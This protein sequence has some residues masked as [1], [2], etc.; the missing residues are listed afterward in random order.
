MDFFFNPR[1]VTVVGASDKGPGSFLLGNL[2]RG[3]Q[4]KVFPVN[5]N[6]QE[7]GGLPCYPSVD[8]IPE[9]VDLALLL[10]P[11]TLAPETLTACVK[12][13]VKGAIIQS[14]GFAEVGEKGRELS[15]QALEIARQGGLRL[16]GPNCMGLV[17]VPNKRFFTLMQPAI[18]N[19]VN[20]PGSISLVVQSGM[21]SAGFLADLMSRHSIGVAKVCSLGNKLDVDECDVLEFLMADPETKVVAMYL[22]S[23]KR[24]RRFIELASVSPKPVVVLKSGVSQAGAKAALSHTASLAGNARLTSNMLAAAGVVQ[25]N[26]FH[27]MMDMALTLNSYPSLPEGGRA[28]VITFSGG[29]GILTCDLLE[30]YGL[31]LAELSPATKQG[32]AEIFPPWMPPENPV[33]LFPAMARMGRVVALEKACEI[34]MADPEV[35]L[36]VF[37]H[38]IGVEPK[39][40][41]IATLKQRSLETGKPV[42]FWGLGLEQ[43]VAAF[44]RQAH[45][46]GV[47]VYGELSRLVECLAQASRWQPEQMGEPISGWTPEE[48]SQGEE[49]VYDEHESKLMLGEA[50]VPVVEEKTANDVAEALTAAQELGFPVVLK[51]LAPGVVHKTEMGMVRLNLDDE[52]KLKAAAREF[53]DKLAGQGCLLVQRQAKGDFELIVGFMRDAQFGPVIMVGLGGVLAELE[54]DVV[55]APAP[56]TQNQALALLGRIR[57]QKLLDGFRGMAPLDR[58]CMA[59]MLVSLGHLCTEDSSIKQV[60][61]NP[62]LTCQGQ[63]LAVDASVVSTGPAV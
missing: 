7:L 29:A 34:V 61:L 21:L 47:P 62:V 14:A 3:Y 24:G 16:W 33:D 31:N 45:E 9:P 58:E 52:A 27:Q 56:L 26:D 46:N 57:N 2:Q 43:G 4:G 60:D 8:A 59:G 63:P 37:H 15:H 22:E 42:V 51:G 13:G 48:A 23:L 19:V 32:L 20:M 36:V 39:E 50:G 54:P 49:T 10:I 28:A 6:Y 53:L 17:D 35:D 12:R 25:A 30:R 38:L 11:A 5:P 44:R 1:S 55:F 40:M 41:D 18:T